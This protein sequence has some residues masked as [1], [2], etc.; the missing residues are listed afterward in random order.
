MGRLLA[1]AS[2][3][4]KDITVASD[5]DW[6]VGDKIFLATSTIQAT[7]SEYRTITAISAG[8]ATLDRALSYYHF[9]AAESTATLYNGIDIRTEVLLMTRNVKIMGEKKDGWAGHILVTDELLNSNEGYVI[10]D[11]VEVEN[12][13]QKD[14]GNAAIRFESALGSSTTYSKI[15]NSAVHE[16]DDWGLSI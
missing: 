9:G 5:L 16:G 2:A 1:E 15:S 14:K 12:C 4:D 10:M 8:K 3:G 7:H 6:A 11:N 13:S